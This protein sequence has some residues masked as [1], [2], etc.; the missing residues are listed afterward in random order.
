AG[1][2]LIHGDQGNDQLLGGTGNDWLFGDNGNDVM[3][4]GPGNDVLVGGRGNDTIL[5][6]EGNDLLVGGRGDDTLDGGSGD[7]I[8]IDWFRKHSKSKKHHSGHGMDFESDGPWVKD[9]V[10]NFG[11]DDDKHH[12]NGKIKIVPP[13]KGQKYAKGKGGYR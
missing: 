7:N 1:N 6:D 11:D 9:F 4:G 10:C 2:D 12:P 5:G 3:D 13:G 8:L